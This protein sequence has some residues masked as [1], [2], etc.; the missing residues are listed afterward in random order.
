MG[1]KSRMMEEYLRAK[2]RSEN[3]EQ[4]RR[5]NIR[6]AL[7]D[8]ERGANQDSSTE[9]HAAGSGV[10]AEGRIP[11]AEEIA[12]QAA[13]DALMQKLLQCKLLVVDP[14]MLRVNEETNKLWHTKSSW[15]ELHV[16]ATI[17][18]GLLLSGFDT[19]SLIQSVALDILFRNRNLIAQSQSGTGKTV[20]FVIGLL[21]KINPSD[22]FP[23]AV[24]LEPTFELALQTAN[25]I[26]K[27]VSKAISVSIIEAV[28]GARR[29]ERGETVSE[30]II[31]GTPGTVLDW[32][33]RF[34]VFDP[35]KIRFFV[36]DEADVMI[37]QQGHQDQSVRIYKMMDQAAVQTAL[38]SATYDPQ[39]MDFAKKI[40]RDPELITVKTEDLSLEN[41]H[42]Y[43]MKLGSDDEKI[44]ALRS[45]YG[46]VTVDNAMVFCRSR[47]M[48]HRIYDALKPD[49]H[50]IG[51]L[52]GDMDVQARATAIEHFREGR[53]R[54]LITT[55][56]SARGI[57]VM[58]VNLVVNFDLPL[59][60]DHK[61]DYETYIHRIGR[62]GRFGRGGLAINFVKGEKDMGVLNAFEKYFQRQIKSLDYQ[63]IDQL[64]Q[65]NDTQTE[66]ASS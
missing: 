40:V 61:P 31:V 5:D 26:R 47:E 36:L 18:R 22:Q 16:P 7:W 4:Q 14:K 23:Q 63:D 49:G 29:L 9:P 60:F 48:A 21:H 2:E 58:S 64:E 52:S 45:L 55:N 39:V 30:Q 28:R 59:T 6:N 34:K 46:V 54:L 27:I 65:L 32:V 17:V 12:Q 25:V 13:D 38:F 42:Q 44:K 43:Y 53:D 37:A 3:Q 20:A 15:Q 24:V 33:T 57:D 1:D 56:V 41:I 10:D 51:I 11:T 35:K 66:G 8:D 19:P 62:T 50:P